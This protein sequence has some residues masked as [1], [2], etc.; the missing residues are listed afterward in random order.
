M[1]S[2]ESSGGISTKYLKTEESQVGGTI[3][4]PRP[5]VRFIKAKLAKMHRSVPLNFSCSTF[6]AKTSYC[7]TKYPCSRTTPFGT[8][9]VPDVKVIMPFVRESVFSIC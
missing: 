2:G 7:F 3:K 6:F 1:V 4:D 8:P 5:E 9:V